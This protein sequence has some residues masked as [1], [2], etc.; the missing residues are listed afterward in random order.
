MS[1]CNCQGCLQR[2]TRG[3]PPPAVVE[4]TMAAAAGCAHGAAHTVGGGGANL[5]AMFPRLQPGRRRERYHAHATLE[6][7]HAYSSTYTRSY[8]AARTRTCTACGAQS[9]TVWASTN[10]ST[11]SGPGCGSSGA[12]RLQIIII[13]GYLLYNLNKY[14]IYIA[15]FSPAANR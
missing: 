4:V 3:S 12:E 9:D 11:V 6:L 10:C 15:R 13:M 14:I 1:P 2:H 8:A 5:V 7:R